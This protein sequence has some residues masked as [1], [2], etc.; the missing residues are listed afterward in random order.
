MVKTGGSVFG[1]FV[2]SYFF[3]NWSIPVFGEVEIGLMDRD[4]DIVSYAV[5]LIIKADIMAA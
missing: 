2:L 5:S 4:L 3:C 1:H